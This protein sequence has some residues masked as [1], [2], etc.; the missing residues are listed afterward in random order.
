MNHSVYGVQLEENIW[1]HFK[2]FRQRRKYEDSISTRIELQELSTVGCEPI[3]I[4]Q[5]FA[6]NNMYP[7]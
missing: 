3:P 6:Q 2:M 7:E 4:P 5:E 1:C